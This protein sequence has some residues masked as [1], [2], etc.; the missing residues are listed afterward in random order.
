MLAPI[1]P[2]PIIPNCILS[3]SRRD[4]DSR[5]TL[6]ARPGSR[7]TAPPGRC[8][9]L[10][11]PITREFI[12][13]SSARA[14][15]GP[16]C[17]GHLCGEASLAR[18]L[19]SQSSRASRDRRTDERG[20]RSPAS[21]T[22]HLVN[23]LSLAR[24]PARLIDSSGFLLLGGRGRARGAVRAGAGASDPSPATCSRRAT[25]RPSR[26]A[27]LGSQLSPTATR[28][29]SMALSRRESPLTA[30]LRSPSEPLPNEPSRR[31]RPVDDS[32]RAANPA[33]W[34]E[35]LQTSRAFSPEGGWVRALRPRA[36][37]LSR[38]I[39][40]IVSGPRRTTLK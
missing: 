23:V 13:P 3:L 7:S 29:R 33:V 17:S 28:V 22:L 12:E 8:G 2:R 21:S 24:N 38:P 18:R 30:A 39:G 27:R 16:Q 34:L 37:L 11:W 6:V 36:R 15:V 32:R 26:Q 20:R 14:T 4:A 19:T 40:P 10:I 25:R 5:E 9:S 31:A 1:R 35:A